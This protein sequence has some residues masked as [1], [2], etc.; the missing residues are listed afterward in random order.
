[1]SVFVY[2]PISFVY[3]FDTIIVANLLAYMEDIQN[4]ICYMVYFQ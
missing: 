3:L 1:M 4:R 2:I